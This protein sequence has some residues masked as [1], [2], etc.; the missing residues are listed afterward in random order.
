MIFPLCSLGGEGFMGQATK[1]QPLVQGKPLLPVAWGSS[2][3]PSLWTVVR[4]VRWVNVRLVL[5][6]EEDNKLVCLRGCSK[7]F[8]CFF[9]GTTHFNSVK[10]FIY[11]CIYLCVYACVCMCAHLH[12]SSCHGIH[13][14]TED[15][16]GELS[17]SF[18]TMWAPEMKIRLSDFD[19]R[20]FYLLSCLTSADIT[21]FIAW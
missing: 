8:L 5:L 21:H 19:N 20:C 16:I 7:I 18:Y 15:N 1:C 6:F 17:L 11:L 3:P 2:A 12:R 4:Q 10:I 9:L 13:V 14:E